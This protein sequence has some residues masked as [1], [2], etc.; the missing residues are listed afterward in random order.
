[1]LYD[2]ANLRIHIKNGEAAWPRSCLK[3]LCF[4]ESVAGTGTVLLAQAPSDIDTAKGRWPAVRC[5]PVRGPG[6]GPQRC[7]ARLDA[8]DE[9]RQRLVLQPHLW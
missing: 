1:M 7:L 5:L 9:L 2:Y 3:R 4:H 8:Q 6:W